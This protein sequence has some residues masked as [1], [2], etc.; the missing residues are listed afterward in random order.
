METQGNFFTIFNEISLDI[1]TQVSHHFSIINEISLDIETRAGLNF[2]TINT[3]MINMLTG[4]GKYINF[5]LQLIKNI[6]PLF[7]MCNSLT[8][9][10]KNISL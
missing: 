8:T 5:I 10:R 1:E 3:A 7:S 9:K 2:F 4:Q 6:L